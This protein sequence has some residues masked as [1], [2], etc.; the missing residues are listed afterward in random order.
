MPSWAF[1][2]CIITLGHGDHRYE[3]MYM[4]LGGW[5]YALYCVKS[6]WLQYTPQ[7][8]TLSQS[9]WSTVHDATYPMESNCSSNGKFNSWKKSCIFYYQSTSAH[10]WHTFKLCG[11]LMSLRLCTWLLD[12]SSSTKYGILLITLKSEMHNETLNGLVNQHI[13]Q[14]SPTNLSL[15]NFSVISHTYNRQKWFLTVL[16]TWQCSLPDDLECRS[17]ICQQSYMAKLVLGVK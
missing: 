2:I 6:I 16:L 9:I 1:N 11:G 4:V 13:L 5:I 12:T 17:E 7:L 3:W 14:R 8:A 10:A 15:C